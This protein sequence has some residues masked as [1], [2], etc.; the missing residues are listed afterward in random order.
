MSGKQGFFYNLSEGLN[1]LIS[2][3]E[4]TVR[5]MQL[6]LEAMSKGNLT[7]RME[8]NYA[9]QFGQLKEDANQTIDT[10]TDVISRIRQA[11]TAVSKYSQEIVAG[12]QDLSQRTEDQ[13]SS[14]Q[15]TA[16]SMASMTSSVKHSAENAF[17]TKLLSM[18][19][20]A[21]AREGGDAINRT[22]DAM[23]DISSAS[24]EISEII[25]VIDDIAFQTNLLALNAAVEAAR[26]GEQGRGFAVV[27][28]EVRNLAQRSAKAAKEIKDLIV[29]SNDKV[30]V[31]AT[32]VSESGQTLSEIVSMVEEMGSKMEEI[33]EAAQEQSGGIDMVNTAI[34][35]MDNMTQ[36]N[37]TLVEEAATASEGMMNMSEEMRE[38]VAFFTIPQDTLIPDV[39]AEYI[40]FI[41]D[42]DVEDD[43]EH[44]A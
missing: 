22:V 20:R 18:K 15:S 11:S 23:D 43:E 37:A 13:A 44:I 27:A 34:T 12:N 26:A 41:D 9:G 19:A 17:A 28:G 30:C 6:L 16:T 35:R 29:A 5:D 39:E 40:E 4:S 10:L 21:K 2:N 38:M 33:S 32:L 36:Q 8:K 14:L 31:G 1:M 3:I 24:Q 42:D 7:R 25:G